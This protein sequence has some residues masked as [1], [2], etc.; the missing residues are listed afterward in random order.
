LLGGEVLQQR[1]EGRG[2]K[3]RVSGQGGRG[4][5]GGGELLGWRRVAH[6]VL[7]ALQNALQLGDALLQQMW[8]IGRA[9]RRGASGY[10]AGR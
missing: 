10:R 9:A 1:E 2:S 3:R 7:L 5:G 4:G 6:L 8:A